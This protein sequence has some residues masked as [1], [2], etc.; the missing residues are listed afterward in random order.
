MKFFF[1]TLKLGYNSSD[2]WKATL[3]STNIIS[4]ISSIPVSTQAKLPAST[5]HFSRKSYLLVHKIV[6]LLVPVFLQ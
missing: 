2:L 5:T 1:I 3:A 4:V 6:N